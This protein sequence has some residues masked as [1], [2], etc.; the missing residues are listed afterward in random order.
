MRSHFFHLLLYSTLVSTF[1][2]VLVRHDRRGRIRLGLTLWSAMVGGA[3]L[4][5]PKHE[6]IAVVASG[7]WIAARMRILPWHSGHSGTS[8]AKTRCINSGQE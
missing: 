5:R 3:R 1:L 2:A 4:G 7:G 8:M 6:R